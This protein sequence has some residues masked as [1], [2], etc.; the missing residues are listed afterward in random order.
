MAYRFLP[1]RSEK[2]FHHGI[3]ALLC[4]PEEWCLAHV[5]R[6]L[7]CRALELER[8]VYYMIIPV[9]RGFPQCR[10]VEIVIC[11]SHINPIDC[12]QQLDNGIMTL[13]RR[14]DEGRFL[15]FVLPVHTHNSQCRYEFRNIDVALFRRHNEMRSVESESSFELIS[16]LYHIQRHSLKMTPYPRDVGQNSCSGE[17]C[18]ALDQA[19]LQAAVCN[20]S[21]VHRSLLKREAPSALAPPYR[22]ELAPEAP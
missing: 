18:L 16:R 15:V 13:L 12:K 4:G 2:P 21:H 8:Q 10:V 14:R 22:P 9:V 6:H 1:I 20:P 7:C 3:M 5:V 11:Q 19:P 17:N